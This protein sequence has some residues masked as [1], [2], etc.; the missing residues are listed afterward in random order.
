MRKKIENNHFNS[1]KKVDNN[2]NL[3]ILKPEL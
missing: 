3:F 2:K 1:Q